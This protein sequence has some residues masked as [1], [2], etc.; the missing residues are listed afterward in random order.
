M[1]DQASEN[2]L[3]K[4]MTKLLRHAPE[5]FG[6]ELNPEDGSCTINALLDA[7]QAQPK[8]SATKLEHIEQ[9]VRNSD[10]QRFEIDGGRIRA[11]YGHSHDRVQYV[12]GEPPSVLYH[13]TNGKAL[14][15]IMKEGIHPM[16]RQYVH[17]SEGTHFAALAGSRR[18]ELVIL[19]VDTAMA[20]QLGVIF[21]YAGNEVWLTDGVP[22]TCCSIWRSEEG[23][24]ESYE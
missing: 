19:K 9:V 10:K 8:W 22:A 23:E 20:K 1:L 2:T 6:V 15:T 13:G 14:P 5:Q 4:L 21:Y 16:S 3:S 12:P 18:G 11:R 7:I 24:E 17:L